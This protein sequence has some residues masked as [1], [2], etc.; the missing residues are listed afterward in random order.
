[1]FL[2]ASSLIRNNFFTHAFWRGAVT[3]VPVTLIGQM[4]SI[5]IVTPPQRQFLQ[6]PSLG[7]MLL[8]IFNTVHTRLLFFV[9][10]LRTYSKALSL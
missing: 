5:I 7:I 3:S 6:L 2:L 9:V 1:M 4:R 10:V 8:S